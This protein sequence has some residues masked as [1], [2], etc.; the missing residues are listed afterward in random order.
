MRTFVLVVD[1]P[2]A[3]VPPDLTDLA[4]LWADRLQTD[5]LTLFPAD[6]LDDPEGLDAIREA[7]HCDETPRD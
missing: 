7:A 5:D 2:D 1:V 3:V 4:T 6:D